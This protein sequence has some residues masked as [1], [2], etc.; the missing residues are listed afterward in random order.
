MSFSPII[1]WQK[2]A[3]NRRL[4]LLCLL[5]FI[6]SGVLSF[7]VFF[8]AEVVERRLLQKLSAEVGIDMRGE[9]VAVLLPV[10]LKLD[11]SIYPEGRGIADLK[12]DDLQITPV[13][14]RL[15]SS[16]PAIKLVGQVSDGRVSGI[17]SQAGDVDLKLEGV[18]IIKLQ[19]PELP[20]RVS[21]ELSGELNG[22]DI[23]KRLA[24]RGAFTF[25]LSDGAVLGLEKI[26]LPG[27]FSFGTLRMTGKFNQRRFSLE[28]VI[29]NGDFLELSGGGNLLIGETPEKTRLNLNI[30]L[31]PTASTPETLLDM[32]KLTGVRPTTDGSY[33]L[34]IGGTLVK[35]LIR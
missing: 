24:G 4:F 33:L 15:F 21:G 7:W 34:R 10:G 30:R 13:W 11:L 14:S 28:K 6:V 1:S 23:S 16:D 35:P 19:Q 18:S 32:L 25:V 5:L 26:G 29:L 8:P 20:Y 17:G 27:R 2:L 31:Q 3:G 12:L 9:N 22:E